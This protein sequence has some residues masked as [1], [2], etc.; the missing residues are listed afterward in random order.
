MLI[1]ERCNPV[2][3]DSFVNRKMYLGCVPIGIKHLL[4]SSAV[5]ISYDFDFVSWPLHFEFPSYTS[6]FWQLEVSS[7]AHVRSR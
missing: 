3:G 7:N 2:L 5:R 6:A 4:H 1:Q